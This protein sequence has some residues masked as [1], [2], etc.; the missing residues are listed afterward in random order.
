MVPH[1]IVDP[2]LRWN[3]AT[4]LRVSVFGIVIIVVLL[5]LRLG[6]LSLGLLGLGVVLLLLL[7][8]L[9]LPEI[10]F[11]DVQLCNVF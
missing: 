6:G 1:D 2:Q 7:G 11:G 10:D 8:L 4:S 5:G 3:H 9:H